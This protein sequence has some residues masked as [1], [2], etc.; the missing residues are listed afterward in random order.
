[1][2]LSVDERTLVADVKSYIDSLED[3]R[4]EVEEHEGGTKT[5][6]VD[7]TI[8]HGEELICIAEFKRPTTLEGATP[9]NIDLV[10]DAYLKSSH[11]RFPPRFFVTSNFNETIVWDNYD[12][13]KPVMA[14][15]IYTV[16]LEK[17]VKNDS[18]F[19]LDETKEEIKTKMQELALYI[20]DLTRGVKKAYYKPLGESFIL[21]LNAHLE[22][23]ASIIKKNVPGNILQKWW[24]EQNYL[25]RF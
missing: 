25:T 21:G 8:Y 12:T 4:A 11:S 16:F 17:R 18:D 10:N 24:K 9:R 14:R 1:M 7:L 20:Y 5:K 22:S 3:F 15:D 13:S 19:N 2:K 23:A 6:R